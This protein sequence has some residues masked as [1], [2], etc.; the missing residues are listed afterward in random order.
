MKND[1]WNERAIEGTFYKNEFFYTITPLPYY[2]KRREILLELLDHYVQNAS[3]IFDFGCGDGW[4]VSYF[5]KKYADKNFSGLDVS[6]EMVNKAKQ[7]NP[8]INFYQSY[9]GI[10][11]NVTY[12]LIYS[13]AVFA[14]I[15]DDD[16]VKLFQNILKS[17]NDDGKFI[18]FEQVGAFSYKGDTFVRRT[19]D[20]Y[21]RLANTAGFQVDTIKHLSFNSH[22]F[23]ER[24]VA[25]KIYRLF[26]KEINY[27]TRLKA[28]NNKV[29]R[30]LSKMFLFFD[31][32]PLIINPDKNLWG[33]S[34]IIL[35]K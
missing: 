20:D 25:K 15:S 35:N 16:V 5:N 19:M 26:G 4:Y 2:I 33:N 29:F 24:Y 22:R 23:F 34:F 1:F 3:K 10:K 13:I 7:L 28:N 27:Q 30:T 14:H 17:L 21:T 18:L 9:D 31:K 11:D 32:N 12:D 8:D 6:Q